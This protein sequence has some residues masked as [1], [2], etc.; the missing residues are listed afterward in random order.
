MPHFL[1][2][3]PNDDATIAVAQALAGRYPNVHVVINELPGPTSKAQNLNYV[4][5]QIKQF[6]QQHHWEF[7][8]LTIHD[9]EDVVH[10]YELLATNYLQSRFGAFAGSTRLADEK[11]VFSRL[12]VSF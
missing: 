2:V 10:P 3:Y 11:A 8:S 5:R 1:G 6:E 9:S 4:I 7:A 12:Q